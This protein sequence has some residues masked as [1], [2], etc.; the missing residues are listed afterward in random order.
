[1]AENFWKYSINIEYIPRYLTSPKLIDWRI[2]YKIWK[3]NFLGIGNEEIENIIPK[4]AWNSC[5]GFAGTVI[6]VDT[7]SVYHHGALRKFERPTLF[8]VYTAKNPKR[9]DLCTQYNDDTFARPEIFT[10]PTAV[11]N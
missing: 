2:Y 6:F 10:Q 7:Q 4:S 3:R 8:F 11:K 9:P 5:P 1:M